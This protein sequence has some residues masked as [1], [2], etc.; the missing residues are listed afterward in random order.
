MGA[1]KVDRPTAI[2]INQHHSGVGI[3]KACYTFSVD[4]SS[5]KR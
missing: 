1:K 4:E 2:G 3:F 5:V